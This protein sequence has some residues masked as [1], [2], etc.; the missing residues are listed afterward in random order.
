MLF[1]VTYQT[2]REDERAGEQ[3]RP[4]AP[5]EWRERN[6]AERRRKLRREEA[7]ARL[8]SIRRE[9]AEV[10]LALTL[11]VVISG[12]GCGA[13]VLL[14]KEFL[15]AG[16]DLFRAGVNISPVETMRRE[17]LGMTPSR[18]FS[19][20]TAVKAGAVGVGL[21][22]SILSTLSF[23]AFLCDP[24]RG[25][26]AA[27]WYMRGWSCLGLAALVYYWHLVTEAFARMSACLFGYI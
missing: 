6:E 4:T 24:M 26:A 7:T 13:A 20:T 9:R 18:S 1:G 21:V 25:G 15:G 16:A 12:V 11:L 5:V 14:G 17:M 3:W 8:L 2:P 19:L 23:T 27:R 10:F 22:C